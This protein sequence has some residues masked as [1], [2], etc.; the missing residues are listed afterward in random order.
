MHFDELH[1][2]LTVC[3]GWGGFFGWFLFLSF[4]RWVLFL[5]FLFLGAVVW[6]WW[7]FVVFGR[8][9]KILDVWSITLSF[10]IISESR[11]NRWC[12]LISCDLIS[13]WSAA[14]NIVCIFTCSVIFLKCLFTISHSLLDVYM[15]HVCM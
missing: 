4:F 7:V 12:S 8:T 3:K 6:F 5:V 2:V 9:G 1:I 15:F 13:H 14:W 10:I 11:N